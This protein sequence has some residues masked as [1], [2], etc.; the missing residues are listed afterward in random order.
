MCISVLARNLFGCTYIIPTIG[1]IF[2]FLLSVY[3][4]CTSS[5]LTTT[6]SPSAA[7]TNSMQP[8]IHR[9]NAYLKKQFIINKSLC[10]MHY[11]PSHRRPAECPPADPW[12]WSPGS[13]CMWPAEWRDPVW[14]RGP[15]KSWTTRASRPTRTAQMSGSNG[16]RSGARIWSWLWAARSYLYKWHEGI[17]MLCLAHFYTLHGP[18]FSGM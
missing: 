17:N 8:A 7:N 12:T 16:G 3:W 2:W 13:A 1:I 18:C 6:N 10:E 9:S 11:V 4:Y 14:R 5:T 15:A